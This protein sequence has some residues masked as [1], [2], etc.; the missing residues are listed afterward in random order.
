ML[1]WNLIREMEHLRREMDELFRGAGFGPMLDA[2][3]LPGVGTRRYPR[4]NI[5][6]DADNYYLEA[7]LP[8][9]DVQHLDMNVVGGT[10][11]LSG[12]RKEDE[13]EGR[14]W[15][16]RERGAG[17]FLRTIELPMEIDA[18]KVNAEYRNGVLRVTLPKAEA[19]KPKRI[20]IKAS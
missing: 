1:S 7:L 15:H 11:T 12:E 19:V 18:N 6:E 2:P 4:I 3:F 9:V 14:T 17:K 8:G 5:R 10:L 16:R 20:A 13:G